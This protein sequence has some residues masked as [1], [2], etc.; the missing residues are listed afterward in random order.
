[1]TLGI[2]SLLFAAFVGNVL[3]GATTGAPIL[4]DLGEMV[5]LFIASGFFVAGILGRE[6]EAIQSGNDQT[7]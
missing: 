1:M 7:R 5:V 2:A 4:G 6:R 3:L